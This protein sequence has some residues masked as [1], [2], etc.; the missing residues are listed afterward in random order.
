MACDGGIWDVECLDMGCGMWGVGYGV[1]YVRY[2][3]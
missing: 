2:G 1:C 3:V